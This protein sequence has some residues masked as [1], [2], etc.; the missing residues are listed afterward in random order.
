M[1]SA[2]KLPKIR[3]NDSVRQPMQVMNNPQKRNF[4]YQRVPSPKI[5]NDHASV[6]PSM[7]V[8]NKPQ[9][10]NFNQVNPSG[11]IFVTDS[12][13]TCKCVVCLREPAIAMLPCRHVAT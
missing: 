7:Q 6:H 11:P 1:Q 8:V 12:D 2:G 3:I 4:N 10:P 9:K 13:D 5:I